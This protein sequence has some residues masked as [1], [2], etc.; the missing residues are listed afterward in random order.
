MRT[1]P[2]GGARIL[3]VLMVPLLVSLMAVSV[4]NVALPAIE[5]G[6]DAGSAD[7]QWVLAGYALS[8]GVVLVAA[9]RAGDLWGRKP[10]FVAGILLF[11][12]GC[13]ASGLAGDPLLLNIARVVTGVGSGLLNPQIIGIIQNTFQGRA[14]GVAYGMFGTVVGLGVAIGPTLGGVIIGAMGPEWGWR[15]TFLVNVPIGLVSALLA[16]LWL[17]PPARKAPPARRSLGALDPVGALLLA[18]AVVALMVP[19]ILPGT[20]GLLVPAV[21]LL[22]LWWWWERRLLRSAE[23]TG[24]FPM[25]DPSLFRIPSFTLSTLASAAFLGAMPGL[26]AVQAIMTQQG[27]GLSALAA[28]LTSLPTAIAVI[29]LSPGIGNHVHRR[30]PGFVILGSVL[31]LL[32]VLLGMVAFHQISAGHWPYWTLALCLFPFGPAQALLMTSVQVLTMNDVPPAEA[33]AAGGVSQTAQRVVTAIGLAA[34]TGTF[35]AALD[36]EPGA[37]DAIAYGEASIAAFVVVAGFLVVTLAAGAFDHARR[38]RNGTLVL[39][40]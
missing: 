3:A 35:Y 25:V 28:G 10:I 2:P 39:E 20:W 12:L 1:L 21:I 4:I 17:H 5:T 9:G 40:E 7:L 11:T 30:G 24:R 18:A 26:W 14:R 23:T 37:A 13:L 36:G 31:A 27:L 32:A 19:F 15:M 6:L 22:G 34:V 16:I 33:G 29:A 38:R 8:F